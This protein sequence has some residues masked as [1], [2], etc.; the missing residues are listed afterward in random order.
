MPDEATE[1]LLDDHATSYAISGRVAWHA[2]YAEPDVVEM[3][4]VWG[5][6]GNPSKLLTLALPHHVDTILE[7]TCDTG[8]KSLKGPLRGV[9]GERWR[10]REPL[11][12]LKWDLGPSTARDEMKTLLQ[13]SSRIE[14]A[15]LSIKFGRLLRGQAALSLRRSHWRRNR[16]VIRN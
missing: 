8:Y 7:S 4:Y 6:A 5:V 12:E 9:V 13:S 2:S 3:S 16:L 15:V 10:F 11:G 14:T 1:A